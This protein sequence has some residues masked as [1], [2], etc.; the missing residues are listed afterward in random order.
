MAT[1][2]G[3]AI[4]APPAAAQGPVDEYCTTITENDKSASDGY[5][6]GDAA[7]ILRQDRANYHKFGFRDRGDQGDR[8]FGS[9]DARARIPAML[10]GGNNDPSVLRQIVAGTPRVCVWIFPSHIYVYVE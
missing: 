6:L 1:M 10:D 2:V 7:S 5:R 8:T 3:L 9:A 4:V